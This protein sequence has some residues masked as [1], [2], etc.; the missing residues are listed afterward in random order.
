MSGSAQEG[1]VWVQGAGE[2]ASGVAWRLLRCGYGV[3]LAER[4]DPLAVRRLVCFA[5]AVHEGRCEVEG[6]P[7]R[8]R[9]AEE[10]DWP[11][12]E[13][14][15]LVDPDAV[16]L[17]RLDPAAV[18]D[19]RMTKR[20]PRP[21]PL[22]K[23]P[24]IGLGPGFRC[25]RDARLVVE[26]HRGARLGRVIESGGASEDT[27][28]PGEVGGETARR[29][30]RA[31]GP[32]RL[33]AL[34]EVGSLVR[35]GQVVARV[36]GRPVTSR[37]DGLLRGLA[38]PGTELSTGEKVGDVDPRGAAIDPALVSDKALAIAGGVLEAL[39]RLGIR[40]PAPR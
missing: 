27:G 8:L 38:Y 12:G 13:A 6:I 9:G 18:V 23:R 16:Q 21:L 24:L 15:V 26:T 2:L 32:G 37:L 40:P 14:T 31:P 5:T 36:G 1:R 25:G 28:V 4:P 7:G 20:P 35:A 29:L 17:P 10:G 33:E 3:I 22:G 34:V 11:D 19:G 39:L 30:L